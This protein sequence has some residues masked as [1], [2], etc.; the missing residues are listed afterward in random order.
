MSQVVGILERM[1]ITDHGIYIDG[2][3]YTLAFLREHFYIYTQPTGNSRFELATSEPKMITTYDTYNNMY[4]I[5]FSSLGK[6]YVTIITNNLILERL[7]AIIINDT[8]F[9]VQIPDQHIQEL[10]PVINHENIIRFQYNPISLGDIYT[11]I[12]PVDPNLC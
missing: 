7:E 12:K 8:H 2:R 10:L 5:F 6:L 4:Y 3:M 11:I 9:T 1:I